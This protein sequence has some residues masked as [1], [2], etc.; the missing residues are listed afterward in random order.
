M[1]GIHRHE[2]TTHSYNATSKTWNAAV[3]SGDN[4]PTY[5]LGYKPNDKVLLYGNHSENFNLGVTAPKGTKNEDQV[6]DPAHTKQNEVGVKYMN[7]G[8]LFTAAYFDIDQSS[9]MTVDSWYKADGKVN[10]KGFE[11]S[12]AGK[13]ARKWNGNLALAW[14]D[15]TY[16][17]N[18]AAWKNGLAATGIP[19]WRGSASVEYEADKNFNVLARATYTGST[20]FFTVTDRTSNATASS[21]RLHA[22][23]FM[24]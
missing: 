23:P 21:L 1:V 12:Y 10:H 3:K 5:S 14:M 22:K 7:H 15:A 19:K 11:L 20:P 8:N 13:L 9:Y 16:E 4:C 24:V 2:G 17:N 18:S 6:M